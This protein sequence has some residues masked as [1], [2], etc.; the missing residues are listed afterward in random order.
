MRDLLLPQ[1]EKLYKLTQ[2]EIGKLFDVSGRTIRNWL[3]EKGE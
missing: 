1:Y 3:D 2:E